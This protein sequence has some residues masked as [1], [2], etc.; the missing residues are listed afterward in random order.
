LGGKFGPALNRETFRMPSGS[1]VIVDYGPDNEVCKLEVPAL[2]PS[3]EK[4]ANADVMKQRMYDFLLDLVPPSMRGREL[5]R[6][7]AAAG[8]ISWSTI[9]YE[10]ITISELRQ[11]NPFD[12]RN[13]ITVSFK[14][15]TCRNRAAQ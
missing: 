12:S 11:A 8:A 9:D 3:N 2:M 10:H 13:T 15:D 1:D 6:F 14:S 4:V 5:G 7:F